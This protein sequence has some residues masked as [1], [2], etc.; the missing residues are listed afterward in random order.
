M[1]IR[2]SSVFGPAVKLDSSGLQHAGLS[3]IDRQARARPT[4]FARILTNFFLLIY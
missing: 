3:N 2:S 1:N 4:E